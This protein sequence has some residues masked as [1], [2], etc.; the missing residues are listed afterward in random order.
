MSKHT[1]RARSGSDRTSLYDEI[2]C[3]IIGELEAGR[4]PWVQPW[5]TAGAKASLAMPKNAATERF[6]S[7]INVLILWSSVI[8][9]GFARQGWLTFRQALG[10]GGNVRKGE[11][12]TT[13]VYADRFI[14]D[15]EKK[16]AR[17]TGEEA[18]AIPFLK[19]FTVFNLAQCEGLPEVVTVAAPPPEPSLIEPTVE[20]LIKATGIDFRIGGNRAFYVPTHDYVQVPTPQAYFEPIN[21]HRT[22]LHEAGHATGHASR[23]GR[24][25]TGSFGTKKY[26]FEEL[27]AEMTAAFT[28]AVLG[29]TPT[30]RHAD[31]IGSW[32]EL[33][34]EDN[35]AV[36]RAASQASKAADYLLAFHPSPDVPAHA[37]S[38][39]RQSAGHP[40]LA[41][42]SIIGHGYAMSTIRN[43]PVDRQEDGSSDRRW[44]IVSEDGQYTTIG[45]AS[46]P[47]DGQI[48]DAENALR[49]Q[50]LAGWLAVMSGSAYGTNLPSLMAVRPL[51]SP[52]K[53]WNE[54]SAACLKAIEKRRSDLEDLERRT[55]T[56]SAEA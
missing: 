9:H 54:V 53:S 4:V 31:Y 2:T 3:K 39:G 21:W 8:E 7:G 55:L 14:P 41:T 20:A 27:V 56:K 12:G 25:L 43:Q 47:T 52:I 36:V 30:V 23:L 16:R 51:A 50:G 35:H 18:Q 49:R 1:A 32:L 13:V 15:E 46:D 42:P 11:H 10:L 28:C 33:L 44:V 29:I 26:A 6:Y 38:G 22:A 34:R 5:G 37:A 48:R 40:C 19:R 17:E 45:R 24:D